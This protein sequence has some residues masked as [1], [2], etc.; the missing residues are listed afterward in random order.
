MRLCD[1]APRPRQTELVAKCF[2]DLDRLV[3]DVEELGRLHLRGSEKPQKAALNSAC[4]RSRSS[5][6]SIASLRT[7]SAQPRSPMP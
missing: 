1:Q 5:P 7:D 6:S 3:G 2:E 4:A